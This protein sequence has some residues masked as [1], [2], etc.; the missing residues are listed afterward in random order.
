MFLSLELFRN[1]KMYS[2]I[3]R[4]Y[5]FATHEVPFFRITP[6]VREIRTALNLID[7]TFRITLAHA[8]NIVQALYRSQSH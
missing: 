6:H 5:I 4:E 2:C 8:G 7:L 1:T 3:H